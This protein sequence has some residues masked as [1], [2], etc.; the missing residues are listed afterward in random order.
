MV[1]DNLLLDVPDLIHEEVGHLGLEREIEDADWPLLVALH[2]V[3]QVSRAVHAVIKV[4]VRHHR[5]LNARIHEELVQEVQPLLAWV[6]PPNPFDWLLVRL[7]ICVDCLL[8]L[9]PE[10]VDFFIFY[11]VLWHV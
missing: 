8:E 6:L 9:I 7:L 4:L 1:L 3:D 10:L 2:V 11:F 5:L